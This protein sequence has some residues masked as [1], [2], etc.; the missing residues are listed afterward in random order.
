MAVTQQFNTTTSM[1]RLTLN[2]LLSFAQFER[3][4]AGE[5]IR[6]KFAASRRKGM[7]MGGTIPLGYDVKNRKLVIN[8]QE[9]DR[10][11]PDAR[12]AWNHPPRHGDGRRIPLERQAPPEPF[13]HRPRHH[14]DGVEW[15]ALLWVARGEQQNAGEPPSRLTSAN[16]SAAP[17]TPENR[18]STVSSRTLTR[19]MPSGRPPRPISR[20]R[21]MRDADAR[22]GD[23]LSHQ[24]RFEHRLPIAGEWVWH[25]RST[26]KRAGPS[27]SA[28]T[29]CRLVR[30]PCGSRN[31][32]P[33]VGDTAF[34]P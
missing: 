19:W 25:K 8:E 30:G 26:P 32:L 24:P 27:H 20:A 14:R 17:S 9:A 21:P 16:T 10:V 23:W 11:R 5:R 2:V 3:E 12:M 34:R 33:P 1:G 31:R 18:P 13:E 28:D 4:L 22:L 6:D 15:A 7:W 29:I